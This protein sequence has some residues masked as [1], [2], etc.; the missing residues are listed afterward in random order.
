MSELYEKS[1]HTLELNRVLS[2]L[3]E[4]CVTEEGK[5]RAVSLRPEIDADEVKVRLRE[6]EGV[7]M[8]KLFR[9]KKGTAL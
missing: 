2:M 5:E 1:L 4:N 8:T 7:D 9:P 3:S 6:T